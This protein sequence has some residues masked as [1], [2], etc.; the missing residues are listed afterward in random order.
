MDTTNWFTPT[1]AAHSLGVS[2]EYI[3]A[4]LKSGRLDHVRTPLGRLVNPESVEQARSENI[5][6]MR[7]RS[8]AVL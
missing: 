3:R 2:V 7:K 4:L 8:V 1:Q 6:Q 5:G